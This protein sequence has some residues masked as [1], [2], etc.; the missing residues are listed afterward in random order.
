MTLIPLRR[1]V[2]V[3]DDKT[4]LLIRCFLWQ[5]SFCGAYSAD[6]LLLKLRI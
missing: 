2:P 1:I 4:F 6:K 5:C 3:V